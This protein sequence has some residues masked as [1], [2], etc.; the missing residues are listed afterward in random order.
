M[1]QVAEI[2]PHWTSTSLSYVVNDVVADDLTMQGAS[3]SAVMV[4]T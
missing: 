1:A 3:A 2:L 4:L